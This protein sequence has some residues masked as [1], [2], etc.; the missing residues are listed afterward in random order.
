[1]QLLTTN[2]AP[3]SWGH[4]DEERNR[5]LNLLRRLPG[6]VVISG[7]VHHAEI[8]TTNPEKIDE[9][10]DRGDI[11][12]V[13]SSGLTHS[14]K[15]LTIL[16]EW[17]LKAFDAHRATFETMDGGKAVFLGKNFGTLHFDWEQKE[18][19][20]DVHDQ[21][22]NVVLSTGKRKIGRASSMTEHDVDRVLKLDGGKFAFSIVSSLIVFF[23][24][25]YGATHKKKRQLLIQGGKDKN[26]SKDN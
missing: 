19:R 10:D 20:A 24:F 21:T 22:G 15:D 7:D 18:L 2:P 4:F 23:I 16:A 3:E 14:V 8:L 11:V 25:I 12:E 13:T 9:S 5:L 17:Q 26:K 6:L 1:M